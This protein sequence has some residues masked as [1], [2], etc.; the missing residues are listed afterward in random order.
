MT[1]CEKSRIPRVSTR[2]GRQD[3]RFGDDKR[4]GNARA[5][6]IV[7][8]GEVGGLVVAVVAETTE[9]RHDYAMLERANVTDSEGL[10]EFGRRDRHIDGYGRY[11][12]V[13]CN[14]PPF[15]LL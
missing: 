15:A 2:L 12:D 14:E 1:V 3:V 11:W 13:R 4:P 10:E 5:L 8:D 7:L 9:T 6:T